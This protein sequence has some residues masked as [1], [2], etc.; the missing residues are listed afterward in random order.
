MNRMIIRADIIIKGKII[1]SRGDYK[2]IIILDNLL[3]SMI[4]AIRTLIGKMNSFKLSVSSI[5]NYISREN[6]IIP[7]M[8]RRRVIFK[9]S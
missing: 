3:S 5:Y 6:T 8:R 7:H 9:I 1:Y 4:G 2:N